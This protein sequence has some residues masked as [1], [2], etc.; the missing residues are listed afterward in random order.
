MNWIDEVRQR[1]KRKNQILF[2]KDSE[3]LQGFIT[4]LRGQDHRTIALWAFEFANES[5]AR[6]EEK[7]PDENRPGEALEA[8]W[9]WATGKIKMRCA[10]RKILDCHAFAKEIDN[11]ED[12]AICHAIGQ[13]CSV[14][15]LS[16]IHI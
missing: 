9:D 8:A 12:I 5:I 3:C 10:Q 11:K 1:Q 4:L 2:G 6:L 14:V 15:H 13:A 7:Y 16:L